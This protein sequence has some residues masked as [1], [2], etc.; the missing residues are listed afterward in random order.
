MCIRDVEQ[1]PFALKLNAIGWF[2]RSG[3][4]ILWLGIAPNK[5]LNGLVYTLGKKLEK[6]G[7]DVDKR[8]FQPH[9]TLARRVKMDA[10]LAE[11]YPHGSVM[12][13]TD[14]KQISLMHSHRSHG[15]LAY[16]PLY[17]HDLMGK[18]EE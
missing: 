3:G 5:A 6:A 15:R 16:T 8:A 1:P 11:M 10:G 13:K 18:D 9:I 14:V 12:I 4:D 7:V 17:H 2:R